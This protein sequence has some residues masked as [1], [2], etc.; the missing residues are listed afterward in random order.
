MK[1]KYPESEL[2]IN[3]DGS[4]FHLHLCPE[5]LAD[6]V[7]LVS[8][9]ASVNL[10]TSH[11]EKIE[12]EVESREFHTITGTYRG[13]RIT[14]Q[15]YGFGSEN[16]D[17]VLNE[18]DTLA[19]IDYKTREEK[20]THRL[21]TMVNIGI[22]EGVQP[23]IAPGTIVVSKKSIGCDGLLNYYAGRNSACDLQFEQCFTEYMCW[24]PIKGSPY[25]VPTDKSLLEQIAQDD[26]L[27]GCTV[28]CIGF[29]APQGRGLRLPLE[30]AN[31]RERLVSFKYEDSEI[32]NIDMESAPII[33]LASL[34]GHRAI[35]CC[36][37]DDACQVSKLEDSKSFQK[38]TR[39]VLARI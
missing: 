32:L 26:L 35:S 28:S 36:L 33:G 34:L 2:I 10:V 19:N 11:F 7:I 39:I 29:Y 23:Q 12:C 3:A 5:Q 21:L 25:V 18:L 6:K 13:K 8:D 1:R 20:E 4:C 37:V 16:I 38:L 24:N 30:N 15:S 22:S 9:P 27:R 31:M 17:I 14:C